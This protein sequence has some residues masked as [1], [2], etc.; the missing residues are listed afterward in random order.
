M[1]GLKDLKGSQWLEILVSRM[2]GDFY[3]TLESHGFET[4]V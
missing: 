4:P 1:T 3:G 2:Y